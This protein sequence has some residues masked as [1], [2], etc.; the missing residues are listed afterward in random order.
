MLRLS[1]WHI[2]VGCCHSLGVNDGA[3]ETAA[4]T[5]DASRSTKGTLLQGDGGWAIVVVD[6]A[7]V[8]LFCRILELLVFDCWC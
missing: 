5:S 7:V 3:L 4:L 1:A 2:G 6:D 8:Q